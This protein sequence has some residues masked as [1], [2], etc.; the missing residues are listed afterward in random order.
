MEFIDLKTQYGQL[1]DQIKTGIDNVL[2]HGRFV[3]GPEVQELETRLAEFV[4]VTHCVSVSSGT[5]ALLIALMA[6]G[7]Q[8][9]D[10]VITTPFSFIASAEIIALLNATPVFVDIDKQTYNIDSDLI[11]AAITPRTKA[12]LPVSLFGQCANFGA[13]TEMA[14]RYEIPVIEDAAQSFGASHRS[15]KSCALSTVGCTSFFPSKP[16]G[17]YGDGGA[18][19]TDN[20]ELA[21]LMRQIRVH[22]ENR[23]YN[24]TTLGINS[25]LDTIQAAVLLAKLTIF[26]DEIRAREQIGARYSELFIENKIPII[27]PHIDP[28]NS[29]VYAQY[30]IQVD[31]RK[32]LQPRL[33]EAGVPTAIHYPL[34]IPRQPV[35]QRLNLTDRSF[36]VAEI[37]AKRVISLPMHPYLTAATQNSIVAAV[38]QLVLEKG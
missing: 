26:D 10:E 33:A 20:D 21:N 22:G 30:T 38:T 31:N 8:P 35:F 4:G 18:C 15:R 37:L 16:L 19:F 3:M 13:I 14:K 28:A 11:E 12:I 2:E 27:V 9:G 24:H 17:C 34:P 32:E 36:P 29:S 23:R 5:D 7:I 1:Q 25:R 6:L